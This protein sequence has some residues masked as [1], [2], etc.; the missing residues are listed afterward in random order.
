[1]FREENIPHTS[2]QVGH[3]I[4]VEPM[5]DTRVQVFSPKQKI[6]KPEVDLL[7]AEAQHCGL[8]FQ[9]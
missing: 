6:Q 8:C 5:T 4:A 9:L 3:P 2:A 1:M 7:I